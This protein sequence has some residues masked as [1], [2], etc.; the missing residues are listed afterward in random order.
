MPLIW[1]DYKIISFQYINTT[2]YSGVDWEA[3]T[4]D[5]HRYAVLHISAVCFIDIIKFCLFVLY[6]T[7]EGNT[8]HTQVQR[9]KR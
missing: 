4:L 3:R 8:V 9:E 6:H 2:V 5:Q 1:T 7:R